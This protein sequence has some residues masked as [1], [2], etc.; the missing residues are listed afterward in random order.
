[1]RTREVVKAELAAAQNRCIDLNNEL[2]ALNAKEL[3]KYNVVFTI[4]TDDD[5][6]MDFGGH[7]T[8]YGNDVDY[9]LKEL[10][11]KLNSAELLWGCESKWE[12]SKEVALEILKES[13]AEW[14]DSGYRDNE[15]PHCHTCGN[16]EVDICFN[17]T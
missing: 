5:F 10:K 11:L 9:L 3:G 6:E 16:Q 8:L 14:R 15:L 1:M 13:F 12:H 2:R 4:D 7:F 17:R